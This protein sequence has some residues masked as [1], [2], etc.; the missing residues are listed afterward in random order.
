MHVQMVFHSGAG[1]AAEVEAHVEPVWMV[2]LTKSVFAHAA[3][4]DDFVGLFRI[5]I[6]QRCDMPVGHYQEMA[7]CVGKKIQNYK[8]IPT[9]KEE[10]IGGV[11]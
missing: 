9:A 2:F 3:E 1:S 10:E 7:G 8:C 5:R 6:G 11:A 4:V